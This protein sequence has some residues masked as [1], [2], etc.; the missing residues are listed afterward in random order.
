[1]PSLIVNA[2]DFGLTEGTTRAIVDAFR[3]GIVTSTSILANGLAFE[4]AIELARQNPALG[5]GVHLTVTEGAPVAPGGTPLA[6]GGQFPLSN[7]PVVRA[8]LRGPGSRTAVR[9]AVQREFE[10]QVGKVV[11]A[12]IQPTHLDGHKYI[13]LLPGIT[14]IVVDV[15]RQFKIPVVRSPHRIGDRPSHPSRLPGMLTLQGMGLLAYPV[16]R[17]AGLCSSDR[18]V[19]FVDTGHLTPDVIRR[20]LLPPVPGVTELLCHPAYRTPVLDELLA[21]GYRWIA[22]YEFESETTTVRDPANRQMIKSAGWT[23]GTF[24]TTFEHKNG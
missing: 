21:R 12:G 23:L 16:I 24:R 10:A 3:T 14:S 9:Q 13:H 7:Q 17:R 20:L 4:T 11:A 18:M 15:A 2:D 5:V 8:L 6:P 22:H 19:G 1:M